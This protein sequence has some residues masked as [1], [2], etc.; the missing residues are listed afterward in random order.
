M[1]DE[2]KQMRMDILELKNA[3]NRN[4]FVGHQEFAKYSDFTERL[5]VPV[6]GTL[7]ST[8]RIGE[9]VCVGGKLYVGA[10]A[11]TW[12]LVGAQSA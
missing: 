4:N 8:C 11:N 10:A 7:P 12:G 9:L 6:Y 3:I 2:L 1:N 5:K